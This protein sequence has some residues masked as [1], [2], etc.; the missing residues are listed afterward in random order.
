MDL[1]SKLKADFYSCA[2]DTHREMCEESIMELE[3]R[4]L[5]V[6]KLKAENSI[7]AEA[8]ASAD[9]QGVVC[10]VETNKNLEFN[11]TELNKICETHMKTIRPLRRTL[12]GVLAYLKTHHSLA[13]YNIGCIE[14]VLEKEK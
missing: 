2:D 4:R 13:R 14:N 7:M 6:E 12:V 5:Q 11:N 8:L 10:L 1:V 9:E 3:K